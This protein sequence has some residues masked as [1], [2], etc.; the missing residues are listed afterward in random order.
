MNI[1]KIYKENGLDYI[2]NIPKNAD[3]LAVRWIECDYKVK[4]FRNSYTI[5]TIRKS[6]AYRERAL[7]NKIMNGKI[8]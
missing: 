8:K 1:K 6:D 4:S 3:D 2:S 5:E 7:I